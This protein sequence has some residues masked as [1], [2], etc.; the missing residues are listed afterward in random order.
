MLGLFFFQQVLSAQY[1]I[2]IIF[3]GAWILKLADADTLP[4]NLFEKLCRFE[5]CHFGLSGIIKIGMIKEIS[6]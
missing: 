6:I 4:C 3:S 5:N 1:I 2:N